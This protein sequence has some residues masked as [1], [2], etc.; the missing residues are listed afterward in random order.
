MS[1]RAAV[2]GVGH[3]GR[4][5]ARI[6]AQT[7][8]VTLAAV[9][10]VDPARAVAV[11]EACGTKG[12]SDYR[13]LPEGL[14]AVS[15]AVPTAAHHAVASHFLSRGVPALVEKP[16]SATSREAESLVALARE[17]GVHL[18]PG[19][20][21][22]FNPAIRAASAAFRSPRYIESLRVAPLQFR[23]LDI[24]VIMDLMIHD[25]DIVLWL[26][27]APVASVEAVGVSVLT[28]AEDMVNAR[29]RFA[30][31]CVAD[32]TA[33]RVAMKTVREIRVFQDDAYF[34]IDYGERR[35]KACR[36]RPGA[37]PDP[38]SLAALLAKGESPLAIMSRFLEITDVPIEEEEPLAAEIR[39]FLATVRDGEPPVVTGE[40]ALG[41]LRVAERIR[42]A[43]HLPAPG[44]AGS[45]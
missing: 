1:F 31:G 32:L 23:S 25:L 30:N 34:S 40:D 29:L 13:D 12:V 22:R 38:R 24:G 2:V 4:H 35:V 21:E 28:G 16:M 3:L 33:S 8:G 19:F 39:A 6:W 15:I 36:K 45:A 11:A 18:Q 26:A 37:A 41:A 14:D 42:G 10:D 43:L 17:R 5:H 7:P 44:A 27:G 9:A 20:V